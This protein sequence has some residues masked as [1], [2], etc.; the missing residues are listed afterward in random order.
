MAKTSAI[1][2][3]TCCIDKFIFRCYTGRRFI[4]I[5]IIFWALIGEPVDTLV[6]IESARYAAANI[7]LAMF[8]LIKLIAKKTTDVRSQ[9]VEQILSLIVDRTTHVTQAIDPFQ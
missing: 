3:A 9:I 4:D 8:L 5:K 2:G 1:H 6:G 7:I